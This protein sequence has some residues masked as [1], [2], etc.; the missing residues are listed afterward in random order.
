MCIGG[1]SVHSGQMF[2]QEGQYFDMPKS[3]LLLDTYST[4]SVTNNKVLISNICDCA[5]GETLN[6]I[7]NG[8]SQLYK[9]MVELVVFPLIV[10]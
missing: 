4:V 8:G 5:K 7:R 10:Y 2:T 9:Q 1:V 3:C 6:A